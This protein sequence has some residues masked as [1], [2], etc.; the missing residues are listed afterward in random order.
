MGIADDTDFPLCPK[1]KK[2]KKG[3]KILWHN[4]SDYADS[5]RR[6]QGNKLHESRCRQTNLS[7][8]KSII[9]EGKLR[10]GVYNTFVVYKAENFKTEWLTPSFSTTT[11]GQEIE[12]FYTMSSGRVMIDKNIQR[13]DR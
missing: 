8:K 9:R 4:N 7:Y 10:G 3:K 5:V 13:V 12:A 11:N 2:G 6:K 1:Q